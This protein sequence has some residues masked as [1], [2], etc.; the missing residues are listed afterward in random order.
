MN[1]KAQLK[2]FEK[3]LDIIRSITRAFE[4]TATQRMAVN[5][6]EIER[7]RGH[8]AQAR[9]T[10]VS[11]K[12]S[13]TR[14]NKKLGSN[15]NLTARAP[16]RAKVILLVSSEPKYYGELLGHMANEFITEIKNGCDGLIIGMPGKEEVDKRSTK[17]INYTFFDFD[18][19]KPDWKVVNQVGKILLEYSQIIVL[20]SQFRSIMAQDVIKEDLAKQLSNDLNVEPKKYLIMPSP[21]VALDY[22]EK[23]L[24]TGSLLEKLYENGLAKTAVRIKILEIGEIAQRL[25][26]AVE[27][28]EKYKRKVNRQINNRKLVN[29]YSGSNVWREKSIITVYR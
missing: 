21:K 22:M 29:L 24:I 2:K 4:H 7:L 19:D 27:K 3:S 12:V 15:V 10:Y 18:D 17:K 9:Q 26:V 1:T 25:S 6:S 20:F 5:K 11:T 28:F 13:I 16:T 8:L 14:K 23:Q